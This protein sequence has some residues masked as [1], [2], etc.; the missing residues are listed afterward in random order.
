MRTAY[1]RPVGFFDR[2]GRQALGNPG[3]RAPA[4]IEGRA[5]RKGSIPFVYRVMYVRRAPT[6]GF[7]KDYFEALWAA[8]EE[9]RVHPRELVLPTGKAHLVVRVAGRPVSAVS[10]DGSSRRRF[11]THAVLGGPSWT[12]RL[13]DVSRPCRTVGAQL[14]PG[15]AQVLFG[16]PADELAGR[17][18]ALEDLWRGARLRERL[19]EV[20][21][22]S[23]QLDLFEALLAERFRTA[24]ALH[25]AVVHAL[26]RL[27]VVDDV[28]RVALETGYSHRHFV[29]LF[30]VA[31]GMPPKRYCRVRRFNRVIDGL[32]NR[33]EVGWA[34]LALSAGFSDQA[35]MV[36]DFRALAGVTPGQYRRMDP[37]WPRHLPLRGQIPSIRGSR[38]A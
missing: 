27:D 38:S 3:S 6:V 7:L 29:S 16:R 20:E 30:R 10:A 28:G 26:E 21:D 1:G 15:V 33:P 31:V 17:R 34:D 2:S 37:E 12:P 11:H 36:R 19:G 35:H 9:A 5:F 8:R 24:P 13:R 32:T 14:R 4:S 22:P 18:V 25:P 23:E